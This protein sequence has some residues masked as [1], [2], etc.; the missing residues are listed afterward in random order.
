MAN[1]QDKSNSLLKT[2]GSV[3]LVTV[4]VV[5]VLTGIL[6]LFNDEDKKEIKDAVKKKAKDTLIGKINP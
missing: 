5:G 6:S 4:G 3:A 2:T 1:N